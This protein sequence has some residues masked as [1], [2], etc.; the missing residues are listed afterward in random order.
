MGAHKRARTNTRWGNARTKMCTQKRARVENAR[1]HFVRSCFLCARVSRERVCERVLTRAREMFARK[2]HARKNAR[3]RIRAH[4]KW[5]YVSVLF[6]LALL[7]ARVS[8]RT[9]DIRVR[10]GVRV[11]NTHAETYT[12]KEHAHDNERTWTIRV[13]FCMQAFAHA[14]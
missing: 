4:A 6:T 14:F 11:R 1:A 10:K 3:T 13:R 9:H 2:T 7:H 5:M 12:A 8:A